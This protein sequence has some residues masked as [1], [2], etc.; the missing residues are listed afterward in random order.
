M[1]KDKHGRVAVAERMSKR[2]T[3]RSALVSVA[4]MRRCSHF[5]QH[6]TRKRCYPT[7]STPHQSCSVCSVCTFK[8]VFYLFPLSELFAH[9][10]L[11]VFEHLL[12][13]VSPY[14]GDQQQQRIVGACRTTRSRQRKDWSND[15]FTL[16][17]SCHIN[18]D[19]NKDK[20]CSFSPAIPSNQFQNN[21]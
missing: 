2:A 10:A 12:F 6:R 9:W 20:E 5:C 4:L 3:G 21:N 19:I 7:T 18:E 16:I 17:F 1:R 8:W 15:D 14:R 11:L 13:F